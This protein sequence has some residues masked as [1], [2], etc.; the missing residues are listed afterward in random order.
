M[1][2]RLMLRLKSWYVCRK[3]PGAGCWEETVCWR[4]LAMDDR[5]GGVN[6][7][8]AE[9]LADQVTGSARQDLVR[10]TQQVTIPSSFVAGWARTA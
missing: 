4:Q 6:E 2:E 1:G 5:R 10:E 9:H 8:G 7:A 3:A